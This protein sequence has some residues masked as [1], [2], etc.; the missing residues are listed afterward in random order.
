M[1]IITEIVDIME[2]YPD[3]DIYKELYI[4]SYFLYFVSI[5]IINKKFISLSLN[6]K[7]DLNN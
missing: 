7:Y 4:Q 5:I 2:T 1:D 3:I 6:T